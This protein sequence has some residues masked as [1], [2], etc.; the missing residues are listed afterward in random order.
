MDEAVRV[1]IATIYGEAA[2]SSPAAWR[3]IAS[4]ILNRVGVREWRKHKTPFDVIVNSGFDAFAQENAPYRVAYRR[5][6]NPLDVPQPDSVLGRLR[7]AVMPIYSRQE[8]PTTSAVLYWSP[9]AQAALH[10]LKPGIWRAL[11]RWDFGLLEEVKVA[12]A[13]KDDFRF[14]RYKVVA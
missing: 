6:G 5:L 13:E 10:A 7:A 3:A 11:P 12:G 2:G 14:Y 4:V 8:P 1:F 9:K